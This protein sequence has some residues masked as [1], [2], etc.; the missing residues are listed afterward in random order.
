MGYTSMRCATIFSKI[1]KVFLIFLLFSIIISLIFTFATINNLLPKYSFKEGKKI[2]NIL[3]KQK[4]FQYKILIIPMTSLIKYNISQPVYSRNIFFWKLPGE[5]YDISPMYKI[6]N[7]NLL[8]YYLFTLINKEQNDLV[9]KKCLNFLSNKYVVIDTNIKP[10]FKHNLTIAYK[11]LSK[12][13]YNPIYS[14]DGY[15]VLENNSVIQ[16]VG[17]LYNQIVLSNISLFDI[18]STA[19]ISIVQKFPVITDYPPSPNSLD[20]LNNSLNS[21]LIIL[22][23]GKNPNFLSFFCKDSDIIYIQKYKEH[24]KDLTLYFKFIQQKWLT[25]PFLIKFLKDYIIYTDL[26]NLELKIPFT[27]KVSKKKYKLFIEYFSTAQWEMEIQKKNYTK[28][29]VKI[30]PSNS[31]QVFKINIKGNDIC[32]IA[33]LRIL[34]RKSGILAL[35]RIILV[36]EKKQRLID[37]KLKNKTII[38][39]FEAESDLYRGN[40]KVPDVVFENGCLLGTPEI[41]NNPDLSNGEAL[42]F[43]ADGKAWQSVDII[44][45]GYYRIGARLE[46]KFEIKIG[47]YIFVVHSPS[48]D[49]KYTPP[50]YLRKG[51]YYLQIL[52]KGYKP[53]LDTVYLYSVSDKNLEATLEDIFKTKDSPAKVKNYKKI[54]PTLWKVKVNAQ[55]PFMLSFA[56]S[57]DPLWEARIYKNGQKIKIVKSIPLYSVI[58]GFWIDQTGDLEIVI[59]YKPQDWFEIGLVI[60]TLTFLGCIGY[61]FYDWRKNKKVGGQ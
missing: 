46:G 8:A 47:N 4:S 5:V 24:I 29:Y 61:L 15:I 34:K 44:K 41:I 33:F 20:F 21:T 28:Y 38:Y 50:F 57:Y 43:N 32:N 37:K 10:I 9:L 36:S 12:A 48:L 51:K 7:A 18:L 54:N 23:K 42:E 59:R 45:E 49:L 40:I 19:D 16:P 3:K 17:I 2:Y 55:K 13:G 11:N 39:L 35:G 30:P 53:I 22:V 26:D 60:S 27:P 14:K 6:N 58:N 1:A 52:P 56:E 25:V 31:F